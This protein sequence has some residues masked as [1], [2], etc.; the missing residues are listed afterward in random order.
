MK[1]ETKRMKKKDFCRAK[2]GRV[3]DSHFSKPFAHERALEGK[4]KAGGKKS[5]ESFERH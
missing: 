2:G 4:R 3:D 1:S 5:V